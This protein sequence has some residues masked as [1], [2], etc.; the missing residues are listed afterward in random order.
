MLRFILGLLFSIILHDGFSQNTQFISSKDGLSSSF[1][2]EIFQSSEGFMYIG[3]G[4]GLNRYDGYEVLH[5]KHNPF[6][7]LSI[8]NSAINCITEDSRGYIWIAFENGSLDIF[9]PQTHLFYHI[10]KFGNQVN[11]HHKIIPIIIFDEEDNLWISLREGKIKKLVLPQNFFQNNNAKDNKKEFVEYEFDIPA[12][13]S[14]SH[15]KLQNNFVT[16]FDFDN[17]GNLYGIT[18]DM[19]VLFVDWKNNAHEIIFQH[20]FKV[21]NPRVSFVKSKDKGLFF[22]WN[23]KLFNIKNKEVSSFTIYDSIH[24]L[25][26]LFFDEEDRLWSGQ[27]F[28]STTQIYLSSLEDFVDGNITKLTDY[29]LKKSKKKLFRDNSGML[30]L[31]NEIGLTILNPNKSKFDHHLKGQ[32]VYNLNP[33]D[34]ENILVSINGGELFIFNTIDKKSLPLNLYFSGLNYKAISLIPIG[35]NEYLGRKHPF[36]PKKNRVTGRIPVEHEFPTF[37]YNKHSNSIKEYGALPYF[38][39]ISVLDKKS[40][41]WSSGKDQYLQTLDTESMSN[42]DWVDSSIFNKLG[43]PIRTE[44]MYV[45]PFNNVWVATSEGIIKTNSNQ[46]LIDPPQFALLQNDPSDINSL[47]NNH[48]KCIIS[49]P[50]DPATFVWFGTSGGGLNKYNLKNDQFTHYTTQN[51]SIPDDV[52]YQIQ[53]DSE[54]NLWI[55]TNRGLSKMDPVTEEFTNYTILDGLQHQEFNTNSS[56]KMPDGTM[57]FGGINGLNEFHPED[58]RTPNN[59]QKPHLRITDL[60]INNEQQSPIKFENPT[61]I[62]TKA[63]DHTEKINLSHHQ[64]TLLFKFAILDFSNPKKNEYEYRLLN[65]DLSEENSKWI[66]NGQENKIQ[67]TNLSPDHYT[68]QVRGKNAYGVE[69]KS[70]QSIQIII[71][72]PWWRS[73][74]AYLLYLISFLSLLYFI[75]KNQIKKARLLDT[76]KFEQKEAE[77]LKELDRIKTNFFSNIT[78]EFRTPLTL[79]LEPLRQLIKEDTGG[80]ITDR[81]H[82]AKDNSEKLLLLVNQLLDISKL[83]AGKM[84]LDLR[85]GSLIAVI[86]PILNSFDIIAKKKKINFDVEMETEI[87]DF[88]FDKNHIEKILYNLLSNALKFTNEGQVLVRVNPVGDSEIKISVSDTGIGIHPNKVPFIFER[89]YQENSSMASAT[90]GTGIG[91]ALTKELVELMSGKISVDSKQFV[92]STFEVILPTDLTPTEKS[93]VS[94]P[95]EYENQVPKFYTSPVDNKSDELH[96]QRAQLDTIL[97]AEDNIELRQFI[98]QSL[99]DNYNLILCENGQQGIDEALNKIPDLIISD[100]AMPIKDGIDLLKYLKNDLRTSHIPIVLLT[101]KSSID[102]KLEGLK[103]GAD[104]YLTKP[105][106]TE[107]LLLRINNLIESRK[108]SQAKNAKNLINVKTE[109]PSDDSISAIDKEFLANISSIMEQNLDNEQFSV[110]MFAQ[111]VFMSRIHLFRKVKA[112]LGISPTTFIRNYRLDKSMELLKNKDMSIIQVSVEVGFTNEKYFSK[113]FKERFGVSPSRI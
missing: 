8:S 109:L 111:K 48:T 15:S 16:D 98:A 59:G 84:N 88:Y 91:L 24:Y 29:D 28:D 65:S 39:Q 74:I 32:S 94:K 47:S 17:Y 23:Q 101:A 50:V 35:G 70:I 12:N 51:S 7:S 33:I 81:L 4:T 18:S 25:D 102:S 105:F 67:F 71:F 34:N 6:D 80:N 14:F 107:E 61:S 108:I 42:I 53:F 37:T 73:K 57:Y 60:Y 63:I 79:I 45:D 75:Y 36:K 76:L 103:F 44:S 1:V 92:G 100:I 43:G 38:N 52:V 3:T 104:D 11:R 82:L 85:K 99:S 9:D 13:Q 31:K 56:V 113:K 54:N 49:D 5:F 78:H 77:R 69:N 106:H 95:M 87:S 10:G 90:S 40:R 21:S 46:Y 30:W 89:F 22:K 97:V 96:S 110:E 86:Q 83:E 55:S 66:S 2:F 58:L 93:S 64:N 72:P 41:L 27:T 68:F 19:Q 20:P 62:L 112:L 26:I